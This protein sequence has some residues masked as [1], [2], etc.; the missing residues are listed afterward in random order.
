VTKELLTK[1]KGRLMRL[2]AELVVDRHLR[3]DKG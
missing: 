1:E 3:I 2:S